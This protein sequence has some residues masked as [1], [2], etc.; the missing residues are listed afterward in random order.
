MS[1]RHAMSPL[2]VVAGLTLFVGAPVARA[3][4][5]PFS[6]DWRAPSGCPSAERVRAEISRLIGPEAHPE[7]ATHVSGEITAQEGGSFRVLLSLEQSGRSGERTLTG[8]SIVGIERAGTN[9]INPGPDE[10]ILAGDRLVLL[11][12]PEQ[13]RLG[14]RFLEEPASL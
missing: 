14:R 3:Q 7:G 12:S 6:L 9:L 10:E 2:C 1:Q 8:A 5:E 4:G 11:G 13:L